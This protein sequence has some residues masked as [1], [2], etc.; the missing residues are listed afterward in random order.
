MSVRRD[1]S[2]LSELAVS[3]QHPGAIAVDAQRVYFGVGA[4]LSTVEQTV[5][6]ARVEKSG[7]RQTP[8]ILITRVFDGGQL[9]PSFYTGFTLHRGS[10]VYAEW[11]HDTA[12]TDIGALKA[13]PLAGGSAALVAGGLN[14]PVAPVSDGS[15]L[16]WVESGRLSTS[17]ASTAGAPSS[18]KRARRSRTWSSTRTSW[19]HLTTTDP[20]PDS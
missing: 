15:T 17:I 1:G 6:I 13:L 10:L 9:A 20:S 3:I 16:A 8:S 11:G 14:H 5:S 18:G 7:T 19:P 2:A 4:L 12:D